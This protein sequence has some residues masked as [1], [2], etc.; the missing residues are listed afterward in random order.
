MRTGI[1]L[2]A[3]VAALTLAL[4]SCVYVPVEPVPAY[5]YAAP[6]PVAPYP[7]AV[8]PRCGRGWHWVRGHHN[9][10]GRWVPGH[11][12]RNWVN[13]SDRTV[14]EP[15]PEAPPSP[16]SGAQV[17]AQPSPPQTSP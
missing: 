8:Y 17:P 15:P 5:R 6:A 10:F 9:R 4:T 11:C 2:A 16:A 13:P 3:L 12:A 7:Q 14:T 1:G